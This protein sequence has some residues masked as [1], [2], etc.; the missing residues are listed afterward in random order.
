[1]STPID[2]TANL[3]ILVKGG[4]ALAVMGF[5]VF[6]GDKIPFRIPLEDYTAAAVSIFGVSSLG[7]GLVELSGNYFYVGWD[8]SSAFVGLIYVTVILLSPLQG[9][10]KLASSL[11]GIPLIFLANLARVALI[12]LDYSAVGPWTFEWSHIVVGPLML[13]ALLV[14]LWYFFASRSQK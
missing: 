14:S 5:I 11:L 6:V 4:F 12:V 7:H 8:C 13:G 1:M 2:T 10:V 9:A 3:K